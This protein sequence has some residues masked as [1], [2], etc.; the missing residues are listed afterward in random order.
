M[1]CRGKS[2]R[3][4]PNGRGQADALLFSEDRNW[5]L[6]TLDWFICVLLSPHNI[7]FFI[8]GI[9]VCEQDTIVITLNLVYFVEVFVTIQEG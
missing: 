9:I 7:R 4:S 6:L 1:Y 5:W 2:Q 8:D 3:A